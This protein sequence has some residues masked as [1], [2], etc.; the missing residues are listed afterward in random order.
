MAI[1][2]K[3]DQRS[4]QTKGDLRKLRLNGQIPGVVYG[5]GL[6]SAANISIDE[7]Q[8]TALLRSQPNA[9]LDLDIPSVGKHSVMV[10][11]VQR[12]ALNRQ[13]IHVDFHQINMNEQVKAHVRIDAVGDST[14]VREGG[15]LQAIL[16]ELEVQC[17]PNSI[18]DAITVDISTLG[19]GESLLV[20]DLTLPEG[21][22][23]K[24]EPQLVVVTILAP[25]KELSEEEKAAQ[26][27]EQH[28]AESRSDHAQHKEIATST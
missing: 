8:L 15:I 4:N 14:G 13:L 2:M 22:E 1:A 26:D 21:V 19:I 16:H 10:A 17:L 7:K 9:V 11:N 23:V 28:E 6:E 20:S 12:D 27:V 3:A 5:R 18:P 24:S 25:Q